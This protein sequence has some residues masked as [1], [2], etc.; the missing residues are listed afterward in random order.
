MSQDWPKLKPIDELERPPFPVD[1]FPDQVRRYI[2]AVSE[3]YQ[4]PP[5]LVG[6]LVLVAGSVAINK[7]FFVQVIPD[8]IEPC[9]LYV[10]VALPPGHRKSPVFTEVMGPI[11]AFEE[12]L[13][14]KAGQRLES[15]RAGRDVFQSSLKNAKVDA[16]KAAPEDRTQAMR[17]VLDIQQQ[18]PERLYVPRI[19]ADNATQ[20]SLISLLAENQGRMAML[21]PEGGIFALMD[22]HYS[23]SG[24]VEIDVYL[25]AHSGDD[26]RCDRVSRDHER[27]SKPSLV[28]GLALLRIPLKPATHST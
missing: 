20:E 11:E 21:S 6:N 14:R 13:R 22:G 26:I 28:L 9:N 17:A 12:S 5:D 7:R 8:W 18:M 23:R 19:I 4:V 24:S 27:V 3:S 2:E 16:I 1:I 10:A 25:K 15:R